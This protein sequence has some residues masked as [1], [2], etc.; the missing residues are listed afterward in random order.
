MPGN[1]E[2]GC[3]DM[4]WPRMMSDAHALRGAT[5]A[6]ALMLT[7][8]DASTTEPEDC[9]LGVTISNPG[10]GWR[11]IP[12]ISIAAAATD[13]R[14]P[15]VHE[16]IEHWNEVL[17]G[18]GTPFRLGTATL[19]TPLADACMAAISTQVLAQGGLRELPAGVRQQPGDLVIALTDADLVSFAFG[20]PAGGRVLVAI[21]S[22]R[23]YPL[24][25]PNVTPNLI[26]HE[27]GH[28]LG[29]GH[30]DDPA[31]LMCGR[32]ASCRPDAFQSPTPRFFPL[33]EMERAHLRALY[34]ATW[35]SQI[36]Q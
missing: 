3:G 35:S 34:P 11:K 29:L 28:A 21:R 32:P 31:M 27:L 20:P 9:T 24:T 7:A 2:P 10:G 26:A 8:C 17:A 18:L 1:S 33:T 12:A 13:P 6:L 23:L 4:S 25:L 36:P 14:I 15:A 19:V 5:A 16:A 30:N 22:P